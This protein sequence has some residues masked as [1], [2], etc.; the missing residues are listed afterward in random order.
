MCKKVEK[1]VL[2][3]TTQVYLLEF[4]GF[5]FLNIMVYGLV[6]ILVLDFQRWLVDN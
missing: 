5:L 3:I 1:E 6:L 2:S 4:W